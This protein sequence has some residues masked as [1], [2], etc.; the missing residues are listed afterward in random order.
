M[1]FA[2]AVK[3]AKVHHLCHIRALIQAASL[4]SW[5]SCSD[6]EDELTLA[7]ACILV[8]MAPHRS[9]LLPGLGLWF[10]ADG[11]QEDGDG[12]KTHCEGCC[13]PR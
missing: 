1:V 10:H 13:N 3:T 2:G 9:R 4:L 12:L 5:S 8:A 6:K 11:A 7:L